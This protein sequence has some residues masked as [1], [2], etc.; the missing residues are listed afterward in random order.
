MDYIK[1]IYGTVLVSIVTTYH[2]KPMKLT[3]NTSTFEPI[4]TICDTVLGIIVTAY[5]DKPLKL[6]DNTN[7]FEPTSNSRRVCLSWL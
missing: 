6:A 5:N 2:V 1:T 7:T 4:K 3:G